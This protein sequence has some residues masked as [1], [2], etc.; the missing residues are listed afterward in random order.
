[1]FINEICWVYVVNYGVY[2]VWKV[3]LI[4]NCEGIFVVCCIIE[5]FMW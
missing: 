4:F 2:G 3:W 1:M 5:W